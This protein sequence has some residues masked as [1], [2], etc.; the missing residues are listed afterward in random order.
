MVH[1]HVA[2]RE[3]SWLILYQLLPK[4]DIMLT[5]ICNARSCNRVL[6]SHVLSQMSLQLVNAVNRSESEGI[7]TAMTPAQMSAS[8]VSVSNRQQAMQMKQFLLRPELIYSCLHR[9][10]PYGQLIL[11]S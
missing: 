4:T 10:C 9:Y 3:G 8:H 11:S 5:M 7:I 1:D 6:A 2:Q